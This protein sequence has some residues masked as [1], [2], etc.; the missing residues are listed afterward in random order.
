MFVKRDKHYP[1]RSGQTSLATAVTNFT[2][3]VT[4]INFRPSTFTPVSNYTRHFSEAKF[5]SQMRI[6]HA[7]PETNRRAHDR[8][9]C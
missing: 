7:V 6:P 1:S 9:E 8:R 3:P 5:A 2:K 4:K